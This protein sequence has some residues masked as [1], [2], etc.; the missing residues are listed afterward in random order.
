MAPAV[1]CIPGRDPGQGIC[2]AA[3]ASTLALPRA[4]ADGARLTVVQQKQMFVE[5]LDGGDKG[6]FSIDCYRS[7]NGIVY[8]PQKPGKRLVLLTTY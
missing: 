5:L 2:A 6:L 3:A 8:W 4:A 1:G 7:W